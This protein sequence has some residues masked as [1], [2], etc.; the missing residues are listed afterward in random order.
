MSL[1]GRN[2]LIGGG[3]IG[4]GLVLGFQ[5]TGNDKP[6]FPHRIDG[7]LQPNA[8]L[9]VTP[10]NRIL[11]QIHKCEMGQGILTGLTTLV[12]EELN[13]AP[14]EIDTEFAGV[15]PDFLNPQFDLQITNASSSMITCYLP[16]REAAASVR[17]LLL[18]AAAQSAQTVVF[19]IQSISFDRFH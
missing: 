1:T 9:Q 2:V 14:E 12:A 4:G 19:T 3:V 15:H 16:V 7:A 6:P 17:T 13:T 5:L 10:D 11:L 18:Q 8:F